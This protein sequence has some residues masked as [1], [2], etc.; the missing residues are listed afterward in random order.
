MQ[1]ILYLQ[2][3]QGTVYGV[4]L[5]PQ[6]WE[7]VRILV[8]KAAA[9]QNPEASPPEPL[10]DWEEFKAYWDF[11]Y[12]FCAKVTC[13]HCGAQSDNWEEDPAHPFMLRTAHLGGLLVF[14]CVACGTSI[15]K[16]HFKDHMVFEYSP[17]AP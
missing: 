8:H 7:K 1:D 4:Q 16:K 5:S 17:P 12:P 11:R 13:A 9:N 10:A 6:L 15:R 2:D 3:K 14:S